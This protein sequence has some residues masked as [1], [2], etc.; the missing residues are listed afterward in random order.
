M[1]IRG[2]DKHGSGAY[3]APRGSRQHNGVDVCCEQGDAVEALSMGRVT[4]IGYPYAQGPKANK[5]KKA[6]RYVQVTDQH[7]LDVR[8]FYLDPL[9]KVGDSVSPGKP[10]G[11]AQGLGHIYKGI[12][13]H[14]HLEVLVM[15]NGHKVFVDPEQYANAQI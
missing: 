2:N 4:K 1:K 6:L 9:V 11:V 7:G 15:I 3:R 8:Y 5:D 10:L 13:E 12:T 14:Y